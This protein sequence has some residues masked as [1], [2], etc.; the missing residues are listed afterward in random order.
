MGSSCWQALGEGPPD[1]WLQGLTGAPLSCRYTLSCQLEPPGQRAG[2]K[3][4][5]FFRSRNI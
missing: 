4:L 5:L 1:M 3:G 2:R